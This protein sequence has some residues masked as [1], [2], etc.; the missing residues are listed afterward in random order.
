MPQHALRRIKAASHHLVHRDVGREAISDPLEV[1]QR[2][3]L[4]DPVVARSDPE[5]LGPLHDPQVRELPAPEEVLDQRRALLDRGPRVREEG[6]ALL[7]RREQPD[8][9]EGHVPPY[10]WPAY[11]HN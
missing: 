6:G 2:G 7:D 3:L 9:V 4:A 11:T 1:E 8:G 5:E 10:A